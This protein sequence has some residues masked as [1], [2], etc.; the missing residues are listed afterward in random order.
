[1]TWHGA[2][3]TFNR[4]I[5]G[6]FKNVINDTGN[7]TCSDSDNGVIMDKIK[8]IPQLPGRL[9]MATGNVG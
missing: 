2:D 1:M 7:T 9:R 6:V 3:I 4:L 5:D 8:K